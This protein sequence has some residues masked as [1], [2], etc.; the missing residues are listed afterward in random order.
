[1][2]QT[3]SKI[4]ANELHTE[5]IYQS[6]AGVSTFGEANITDLHVEGGKVYVNKNSGIISATAFYAPSGVSTFTNIRLTNGQDTYINAKYI[7]INTT[8]PAITHGVEVYGGV[9]EIS[10]GG[11]TF[12]IG[13]GSTAGARQDDSKLYVGYGRSQNGSLTNTVSKILNL[14]L[15]K[16]ELSYPMAILPLKEIL[17][18]QSNQFCIAQFQPMQSLLHCRCIN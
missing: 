15:L 5:N 3:S 7:G 17:S 1:M 16:K 18:R 10:V 8:A 9:G 11:E 6:L 4:I 14:V 2:W 12:G 13:I